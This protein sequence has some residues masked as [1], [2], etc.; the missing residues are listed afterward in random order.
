MSTTAPLPKNSFLV[1]R[2]NLIGSLIAVLLAWGFCALVGGVLFLTDENPN[3]TVIILSL[4]PFALVITYYGLIKGLLQG[5][6]AI[7]VGK[8]GFVLVRGKNDTPF[9]H[10]D[11]IQDF[12]LGKLGRSPVHD[13]IDAP[14]MHVINNDG[15]VRADWLPGNTG[16]MPQTL[17]DVMEYLRELHRQGW[18]VTP[19]RLPEI[20]A[21]LKAQHDKTLEDGA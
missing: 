18:P 6:G 16:L 12:H 2:P 8:E 9:Y 17:I 13:G 5:A 7:H 10:W 1:I 15:T 3:L 19:T 4:A 11:A 21:A 14:H 20:H